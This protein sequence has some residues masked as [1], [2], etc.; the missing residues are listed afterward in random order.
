MNP[1]A[2]MMGKMYNPK[3]IIMNVLKN[4][5][6]PKIQ[7]LVQM[8]NNNDTKGLEE[9]ARKLC[10]TKGINFDEVFPNFMKHFNK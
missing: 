2:S 1:L 5:N 4:N 8:A 6:D 7:E 10:E 3:N 9:Y